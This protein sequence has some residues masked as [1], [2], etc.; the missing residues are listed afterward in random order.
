MFLGKNSTPLAS[1]A[2]ALLTLGSGSAQAG[3]VT[4]TVQNTSQVN[5]TVTG[6]LFGGAV[7]A[8]EQQANALTKYNGTVA[9]GTNPT[10]LNFAGGGAATAINPTGGFFNTP[11]QY[12]PNVSGAAGTAPANYGVNLNAPVT[13]VIPPIDIPQS[14][15]DA[16][17]SP[18]N[19]LVPA[20]LN[21]GTL[22]AV[23]A[24]TAIRDF[25][26]D[27][28]ALD[29]VALAGNTFDANAVSVVVTNGFLDVNLSAR[30]TQDN[31]V[32]KFALQAIL[33]GIASSAPQ[34]GLTVTSP[35]LFSLDLDIG[36]GTRI[37]L[38]NLNL[39]IANTAVADGTITNL[40]T[41]SVS[42]LTLPVQ[43]ELTSTLDNALGGLSSVLPGLLDLQ[44]NFQ[45]TVTAKATV[46]EASTFVMTGL[47]LV[48]GAVTL[49]RRRKQS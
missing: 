24:K 31:I 35:S 43:F 40:G 14:V 11:L 34:L 49:L 13:Y 20:T 7:T 38:S 2:F 18:L 21:L 29:Y 48:P 32:N 8:T 19:T 3:V 44:L 33:S 5:L 30:L 4:W 41:H 46:P 42:T 10:G 16:L 9:L 22:S 23:V 26:L 47:I 1:L 37:D 17:P 39:P 28:T 27:F 45:G 12:S 6:N 15:R 36:L 25:A